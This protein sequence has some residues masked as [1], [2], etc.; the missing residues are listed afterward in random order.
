[1]T[2]ES[3]GVLLLLVGSCTCDQAGDMKLSGSWAL[4]KGKSRLSTGCVATNCPA[5]FCTRTERSSG[6]A[7][8][9]FHIP[10]STLFHT[11]VQQH[12]LLRCKGED[13]AESTGDGAEDQGNC[14]NSARSNAARNLALEH[15]SLLVAMSV[16]PT[17]TKQ[18]SDATGQGMQV[19]DSI[20]AAEKIL[21]AN[22][23]PR[24][25]KHSG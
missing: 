11:A 21:K 7:L 24:Y 8:F 15:I 16:W 9:D 25:G 1:M 5:A 4:E 14:C 10:L 20:V 12:W 19:R 2:T 17:R 13:L 23:I 3:I 18:W 22:G 6:S